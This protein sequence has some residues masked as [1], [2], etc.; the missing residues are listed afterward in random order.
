MGPQNLISAPTVQGPGRFWLNL[1]PS[2]GEAGT[3]IKSVQLRKRRHRGLTQRGTAGGQGLTAL[4]ALG[5]P[6]GPDGLQA[7]ALP[8]KAKQRGYGGTVQGHLRVP[9]FTLAPT[10]MRTKEPTP[11]PWSPA[12]GLDGPSLAGGWVPMSGSD[13]GVGPW[14]LLGHL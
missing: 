1:F 8:R 14:S 13:L 9:P 4:L 3:R 7:P 10:W 6:G 11:P 5:G 12:L 2:L